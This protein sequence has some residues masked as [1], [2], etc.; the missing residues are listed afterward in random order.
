MDS[1]GIFWVLLDPGWMYPR[2]EVCGGRMEDA[3]TT[4]SRD[5][6]HKSTKSCKRG[7]V[8]YKGKRTIR[9]KW[10]E[11]GSLRLGVDHL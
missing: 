4:K 6:R 3:P 9:V 7:T 2:T 11:D 5:G 8:E 10:T 1:N